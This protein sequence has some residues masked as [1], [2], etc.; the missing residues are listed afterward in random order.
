[1]QS[2]RHLRHSI[3]HGALL[4]LDRHVDEHDHGDGDAD[5]R[6]ERSKFASVDTAA[7]VGRIC[8][9]PGDAT[10]AV[11]ASARDKQVVARQRRPALELTEPL[12]QRSLIAVAASRTRL[13]S[14]SSSR[15][16]AL[17]ARLARSASAAA[18]P[19]PTRS[20]TAARSDIPRSAAYA[21]V[22]RFRSASTRA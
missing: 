22:A 12:L 17:R 2:C 10:G 16:R 5:A 4:A 15:T 3:I 21:S 1:M 19:F 18:R 11:R 20:D 8:Q 9:Q 7:P 6:E 14:V 13:I